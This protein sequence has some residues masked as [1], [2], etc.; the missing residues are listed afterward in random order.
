MKNNIDISG[1]SSVDAIAMSSLPLP[2]AL[3]PL[4]GMV[5]CG[6]GYSKV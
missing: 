4:C 3:L 6:R 2:L 1:V 5:S